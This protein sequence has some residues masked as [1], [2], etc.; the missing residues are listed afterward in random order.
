VTVSPLRSNPYAALPELL[1]AVPELQATVERQGKEI[2]E[3][4]E[5]VDRVR[6]Q[7]VK[8]PGCGCE[9][10]RTVKAIPTPRGIKR[11]RECNNE[12]CRRRFTTYEVIG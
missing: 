3:L 4:R 2:A 8:C 7:S 6:R 11:R 1:A 10:F 9:V 12:E 5:R